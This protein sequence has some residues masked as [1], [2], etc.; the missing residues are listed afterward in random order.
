MIRDRT[1]ENRTTSGAVYSSNRRLSLALLLRLY[2][3]LLASLLASFEVGLK[4]SVS[5]N[6]RKLTQ[7][8]AFQIASL[9][10]CT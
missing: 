1:S 3:L 2:S 10:P 9:P 4:I 8:H 6:M 7:N 5:Y